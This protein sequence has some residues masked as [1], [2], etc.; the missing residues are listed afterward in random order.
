[1]APE[2]RVKALA[3]Q[4]GFSLCGIAGLDSPPERLG[5]YSE[6]L[7]LGFA[8]DMAYL[9]RQ[10]EKRLD[11]RRVLPGAKSMV[12]LGLLYNT[13]RPYSTE[14]GP[15]PWISRYAW[16]DDYH[17]VMGSRLEVLEASLR[18][19]FGPA[20][21]LKSCVDTAPVAEKAWA[22]AAG[23]GWT[24]KNTCLIHP[25]LGSWLFL[26]EILTDLE[27]RADPPGADLCGQ[28]RRC[29]DACPTQ[30]FPEPY[31]LDARRC[32]SYLTIEKRGEIPGEFR[33]ALGAHLYGCDL[34]QDVCPWNHWKRTTDEPAFQKRESLESLDPA[35]VEAMDQAEFSRRFKGSAMKRTKLEG[36]KRNARVVADNL[37]RWIGRRP[38]R[39]PQP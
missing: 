3:L 38:S 29:L 1:M 23:L 14:A 30:A 31:V 39:D 2:E 5:F 24:G 36:L 37:R 17:Q 12:C 32:V 22:Q 10:E 27:L 18:R 9:G 4:A 16:G 33:Q 7:K 15:G 11:P 25:K 28:C 6:W 13:D 19:E 8:G 35:A 21:A 20:V 34:C 26:A